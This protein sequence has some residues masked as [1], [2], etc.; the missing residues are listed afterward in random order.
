MKA[1]S[2]T[3][4]ID[5]MVAHL[6]SMKKRS[7]CWGGHCL[8][9]TADGNKCPVGCLLPDGHPGQKF[10]GAV[11]R[12]LQ[13]Y[14]DLRARVDLDIGQEFQNFHDHSNSWNKSGGIKKKEL[15]KVEQRIRE[16]YV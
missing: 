13:S 4:Q 2:K 14:P 6:R 16:D 8:Y 11:G 9:L 10:N 3:E 12:L 7:D 15:K 5:T 1:L